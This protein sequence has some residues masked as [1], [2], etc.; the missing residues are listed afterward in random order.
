[1]NKRLKGCN[2]ILKGCN[3]RLKGCNERLKGCNKR[4][5]GCN[6]RL[7]GCNER[8]LSV[9]FIFVLA[10]SSYQYILYSFLLNRSCFLAICTQLYKLVLTCIRSF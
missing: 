10:I 7:K 4:L 1:M 9:Y 5:Q 3:K 8:F 6:K 2:K